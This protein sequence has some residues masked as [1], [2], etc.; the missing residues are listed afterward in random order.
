[1]PRK[2]WS[3]PASFDHDRTPFQRELDE[4]CSLVFCYFVLFFFFSS[5]ALTVFKLKIQGPVVE[6]KLYSGLGLS[7]VLFSFWLGH[8]TD[9]S[10]VV[11]LIMNRSDYSAPL[12]YRSL[13]FVLFYDE[14]AMVANKL[15]SFLL[16]CAR[17]TKFFRWWICNT[18]HSVGWT[19]GQQ[20]EFWYI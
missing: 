12:Q 16:N 13:V 1:M 10:C 11:P 9:I 6:T 18:Q 8:Q 19:R 3:S 7:T 5:A 4:Y 20:R 17:E 2:L 15:P 14:S